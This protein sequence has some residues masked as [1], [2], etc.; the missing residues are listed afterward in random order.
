[1]KFFNRQRLLHTNRYL[2]WKIVIVMA[3]ILLIIAVIRWFNKSISEIKLS[4][5]GLAEEKL[6]TLK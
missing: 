6:I 3:A 1:M 2:V 5:K 4:T